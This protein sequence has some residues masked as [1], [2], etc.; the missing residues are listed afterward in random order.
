MNARQ[1]YAQ[2]ARTKAD[3][4]RYLGDRKVEQSY[5]QVHDLF[6]CWMAH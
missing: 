5:C 6:N 4:V 3:W 1:R 2:S